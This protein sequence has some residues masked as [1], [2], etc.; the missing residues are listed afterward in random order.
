MNYHELREWVDAEPFQPFRLYTT[1]GRSFDITSPNMI[2][3]GRHTVLIGLPDNPAEPD[4]PAR[5]ITLAMLH[6][7]SA[8]PIPAASAA[9]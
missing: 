9:G 4:V 8:E 2:W 5:H 6:I 7:V 1:D 3:P